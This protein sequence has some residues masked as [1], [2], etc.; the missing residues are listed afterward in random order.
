MVWLFGG[1]M[2]L[3]STPGVGSTFGF[4]IPG[5][6]KQADDVGSPERDELPVV[7]LVDDDRASLDLISAY[8]DGSPTR[9]LR[10]RDG[11][12]ALELIAQGAAG[13]RG[14]RHQAATARWLAGTGR[15]QGGP[16]HRRYPSGHRLRRRRSVR[17]AWPWVRTRI[18]ASQFVARSWWMRCDA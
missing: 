1:R 17:A 6:L 4:S 5:L 14:A 9:V 8:L 10:A 11:V 15:A 12:E 16:R 7:V 2:W 13:R 3:E 18:C